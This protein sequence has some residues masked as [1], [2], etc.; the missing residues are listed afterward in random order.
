MNGC[1]DTS[2]PLPCTLPLAEHPQENMLTIFGKCT[3]RRHYLHIILLAL[4]SQHKTFINL[5]TPFDGLPNAN[6]GRPQWLRKWIIAAG[7][8]LLAAARYRLRHES[9]HHFIGLPCVIE[10]C[11]FLIVRDCIACYYHL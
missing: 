9:W 2:D 7:I 4:L 8:T 6:V 1:N 10:D 11:F 5:R 3:F